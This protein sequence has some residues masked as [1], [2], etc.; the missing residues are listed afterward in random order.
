MTIVAQITT[1]NELL[2]RYAASRNDGDF[3]LLA[4]RHLDWIFS[5]ALRRTGKA[6]LA[7]EVTQGVLLTLAQKAG[8]LQ[9]HPS[10]VSWLFRAT[11]YAANNLL[12]AERRRHHYEREAMPNTAETLDPELL[13]RLDVAI[14]KLGEAERE[15]ILLRF[16]QRLPHAAVAG[17]LRISEDAARQRINRAVEKLRKL[18]GVKS[19]ATLTGA[20]TGSLI[21]AAP[22]HLLALSMAPHAL[23][24]SRAVDVGF[25]LAKLKWVAAVL[26]VLIPVAIAAAVIKARPA[27]VATSVVAATSAPAAP[28]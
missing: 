22:K 24:A 28:V 11:Q 16:Y 6:A 3:R 21:V 8:S 23:A 18:L 15:A 4:A 2:G 13:E 25:A 26:V 10:L 14:G 17:E 19:A 1:D 7:E 5:V 27:P 20:L 12:R 9:G